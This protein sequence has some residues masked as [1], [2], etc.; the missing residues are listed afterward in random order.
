MG[1]WREKSARFSHFPRKEY[2]GWPDFNNLIYL[3][4]ARFARCHPLDQAN[5]FSLAWGFLWL[6]MPLLKAL[7]PSRSNDRR[8]LGR[9]PLCVFEIIPPSP[10][11]NLNISASLLYMT[12]IIL[13]TFVVG[14]RQ[15]W[16]QLLLNVLKRLWLSGKKREHRSASK[17]VFLQKRITI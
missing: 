3:M 10:F 15:N 11:L 12:I 7:Y 13:S 14:L 17:Y 1:R 5:S 16:H 8:Y 2:F 4:V 6:G 9:P